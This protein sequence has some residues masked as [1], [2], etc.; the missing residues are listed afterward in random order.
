MP[1]I[2]KIN[3]DIKSAMLSKNKDRL[4][5]LRSVKAAFLLALTEKGGTHQLTDEAALKIIAKLL[6][7]RK[8]SAII[9]KEQN[10]NDLYQKEM[11]EAA[12]LEEYLP[13][14]LT[15]EEL[16]KVLKDIISQAGATSVAD[17]GK[18]MAVASKQLAGKAEGKIVAAKAREIL[19]G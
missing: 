13:V 4:E 12:V 2:E 17:M 5:T 9:Y 19:G 16:T 14:P 15:E 6:K 7:Q 8:D 11:T 1:L 18:V 10:R 3:E